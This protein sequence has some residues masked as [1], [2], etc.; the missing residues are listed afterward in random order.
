MKLKLQFGYGMKGLSEHL[1]DV[2]PGTSVVLSPRDID[3]DKAMSFASKMRKNGGSVLLDPQ[4]Y[5]LSGSQDLKVV[6]KY[7]FWQHR[8]IKNKLQLFPY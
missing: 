7:D 4:V 6:P 3:Q 1:A 8:E 2:L 5:A